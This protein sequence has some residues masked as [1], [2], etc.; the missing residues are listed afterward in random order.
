M[1]ISSWRY[2][3]KKEKARKDAD[4]REQLPTYTSAWRARL[5]DVATW[6]ASHLRRT[7]RRVQVCSGMQKQ[8][9]A[10]KNNGKQLIYC[11]TLV[12]DGVFSKTDQATRDVAA[13][14]LNAATVGVTPVNIY[15]R[16]TV[17]LL[18]VFWTTAL[19]RKRT[20]TGAVVSR[21]LINSFLRMW[22][23]LI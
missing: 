8:K 18:N 3:S 16:K 12:I 15:E 20:T 7:Y 4:S 13:C 19:S 21:I 1:E 2:L 11:S 5:R 9:K 23:T 14:L 17:N 6:H 22:G 10:Q